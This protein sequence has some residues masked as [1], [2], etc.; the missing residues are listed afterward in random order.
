M[1]SEI[2]QR[3]A[4]SL[5]P[6]YSRQQVEFVTGEGPWLVDAQGRRY[7]DFLSGLS[8][9]ALGH[10]H[11]EVAEA[12]A[13]QARRLVHVSN[14]YYTAGQVELAERLKDLLGWP[15]GRAF[16]A[17]SG[18]EA[19]E[20]A[21]KLARRH[22]LA[23]RD[24]KVNVVSLE[25]SFHGRLLG[26]LLLTGNPAKH[27]P[28]QPLG[29]WVTHVPF[30]DPAA[31]EAAVD[32]DTCAVWVEVVQGEGG[33]RPVP[34]AVLRAA[35]AACDRVGALLVADEVQTG[36]GRLGAWFGWQTTGSRGAQ[37]ALEPDVVCLAKGLAGGL[38]I[39]A[40]LAHG[41]AARA[42][43]P[44]DHATTFGGGPVI[45]AAALAVLGIIERDGLVDA[46]AKWGAALAES[47]DELI[48]THDLAAGRRGLGLLQA[49]VLAEPLAA[50]VTAAALAEGLVVNNVVPD[51]VRLA[52]P[53]T[54]GRAEV[55]EAITRLSRALAHVANTIQTKEGASR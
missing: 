27:V 24:G 6:T 7:L 31:L 12:V 22:G 21:I 20:A 2:A 5:L 50:E 45:C 44:G 15:D 52:P 8:V 47:L 19:N 11:P 23:Q 10:A 33:V 1:V 41:E 40:I 34:E 53:L 54:I 36:I 9:T 46:A 26:P 39:G 49:L 14:L 16:F 43:R 17:N 32:E 38:P 3:E 30:D 35:R 18:A 13:T 48:A 55:D 25:G 28:F 37:D 29:E 42:F 4:A 51:A